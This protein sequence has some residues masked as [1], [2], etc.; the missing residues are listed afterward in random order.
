MLKFALSYFNCFNLFFYNEFIYM[1][2]LFHCN[3]DKLKKNELH[4]PC[5]VSVWDNYVILKAWYWNITSKTTP[6]YK[7]Q[8]RSY[9]RAFLLRPTSV[10]RQRE[11][12]KMHLVFDR[13]LFSPLS[14]NFFRS[15]FNHITRT[16][17][18]LH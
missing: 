9:P 5:S 18:V 1:G 16:Y 15:E 17:K 14:L 13:T 11:V 6:V 7:N 2:Q 8:P 12:G 3:T 4:L 10:S